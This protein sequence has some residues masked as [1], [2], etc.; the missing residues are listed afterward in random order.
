MLSLGGYVAFDLPRTVTGVGA[1][2]LLGNA[3]SHLYVL[4]SQ[5]ALPWYFVVYATSVIA[6]CALSAGTICLGR[7]SV[8]E[9]GWLLGSLLSLA[10]VGADIGT[11]MASLAAMTSVTGRWDFAPATF[12]LAFAG[13]FLALRAT[14]LLRI[15]VAYPQRQHWAD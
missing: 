12:A 7:S 11:R 2:L 6:G 4:T 9:S 3:A 15:N 8:I 5:P 13:A 14:V 1:L 10:V